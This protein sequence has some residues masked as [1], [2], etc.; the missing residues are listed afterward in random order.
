MVEDT[1][2]FQSMAGFRR[3]QAYRYAVLIRQIINFFF[4]FFIGIPVR[5]LVKKQVQVKC[6]R[7][8]LHSPSIA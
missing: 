6:F 2:L 8:T 4:R 3:L 7:F 1:I 5:C